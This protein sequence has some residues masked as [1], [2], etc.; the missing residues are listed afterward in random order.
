MLPKVVPWNPLAS[1]EVVLEASD[2]GIKV[3]SQFR[4][5]I[6]GERDRGRDARQVAQEVWV[7]SDSKFALLVVNGRYLPSYVG[8]FPPLLANGQIIAVIGGPLSE[9][10]DICPAIEVDEHIGVAHI[11]P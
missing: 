9:L 7:D 1:L 10:A 4:P 3:C 5:H 8:L 6:E 2:D 11:V